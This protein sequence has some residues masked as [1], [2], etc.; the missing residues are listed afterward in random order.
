MTVNNL[1]AELE[2]QGLKLYLSSKKKIKVATDSTE[3]SDDA[4]ELLKSVKGREIEIIKHLEKSKLCWMVYGK[5]GDMTE[6]EWK[7]LL[8]DAKKE[9][10]ADQE[11]DRGKAQNKVYFIRAVLNYLEKKDEDKSLYKHIWENMPISN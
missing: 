2:E 9:V 3:I 1:I 6:K 11:A 8:R 7:F 4:R 10:A 5:P